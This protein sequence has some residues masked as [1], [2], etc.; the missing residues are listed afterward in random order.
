MRFSSATYAVSETAGN[1]TITV[2][3][4][5]GSTGAVSVSY[6]T[7]AGGSAIA[8]TDYLGSASTLSWVD[9]DIADKT[10]SVTIF[11]DMAVDGNKTVN[12]QLSNPAGGAALGSLSTATLTILANDSP[13]PGALR[14][15]KAL[16]LTSEGGG[17][18]TITVSRVGGTAGAVSVDYTTGGGTAA[19]GS[20]YTTSSG[21]LNWANGDAADKTFTV[22]IT[23]DS[24]IEGLEWTFLVLSNPTGSATLRSPRSAVLA[25]IDNEPAGQQLSPPTIA[26]AFG[27]A[28]LPLTGSTT[29]SFDIAN[30]NAGAALSG[31]GFTDDLPAGLVAA[32]PN[33][34]SGSCGGG[35]IA[36]TAGSNT[37]SL[38]GATLAASSNC[39]FSVAVTGIAAGVKDNTTDPI[40]WGVGSTG[41]PSNTATL[42]VIPTLDIDGSLTATRYD[43]LTDGLLIIR[44]LFGLTGTP[45]TNNA[46][47]GTAARTTPAE[48]ETYLANIRSALD[49]DGNGIADALTDGLMVLRYMFVLRGNPLI[50]NAF[51]PAGSRNTAPAIE[52]YILSLMPQ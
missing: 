21:T 37:V 47:G 10:F 1:A 6:A 33:G 46:L 39:V 30:P 3:R 50:A 51:D 18:A 12:L 52:A 20:D 5:G 26:K 31:I 43:A 23:D 11:D 32:T 8:G 28:A 15:S 41:A 13:A 22:P 49:I 36:A 29:L 2:S 34:L 45:L 27:T 16:Y 9:G 17:L 40:A 24:I 7:V 19:A 44:Y 35:T 25:I 48:V 38:S 14:F 42:T 4:V